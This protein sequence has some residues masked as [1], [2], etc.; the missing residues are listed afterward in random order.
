MA[1]GFYAAEGYAGVGGYHLVDED[2]AGLKVVDEVFTLAGIVCP[3]AR[4]EAKPAVVGDGD[5]LIDALHTKDTRDG[6]EEFLGVGGGVLGDV[7]KNRWWIEI[8]VASEGL[9]A[10]E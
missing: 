7:R 4:T 6:A 2:H 3:G 8:P 10:D 1:R 5:C 9:A